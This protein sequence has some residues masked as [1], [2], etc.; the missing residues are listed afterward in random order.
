MGLFD[1]FPQAV[2]GQASFFCLCGEEK[3]FRFR[4]EAADLI[5]SRR[6]FSA[7]T[8]GAGH[9]QLCGRGQGHSKKEAEQMA[10]KEAL[11]LM[12]E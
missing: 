5:R 10:A 12:G 4:G 7:R 8:D 6:C 11:E 2:I 1:S 3:P 9:Q